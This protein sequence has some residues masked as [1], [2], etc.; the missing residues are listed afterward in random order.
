ML[1][2]ANNTISN[3]AKQTNLLAMNAAIEA[4]HAGD[5]GKGF[6]VVADEIRKLSETSSAQTITMTK[7]RKQTNLL[8]RLSLPWRNR[9][10]VQ[11]RLAMSLE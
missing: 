10:P 11:N 9:M 5:A 1:H 2:E 7:F 8:F 3:I 4:A 6:S